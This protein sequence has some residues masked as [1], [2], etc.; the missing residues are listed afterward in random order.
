MSEPCISIKG[1]DILPV[2]KACG[3]D[4]ITTDGKINRTQAEKCW[5]ILSAFLGENAKTETLRKE[6]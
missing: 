3:V 2:I 5:K 4:K 1:E 6:K